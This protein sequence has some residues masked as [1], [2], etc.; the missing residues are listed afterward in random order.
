MLENLDLE[1]TNK[2]ICEKGMNCLKLLTCTNYC[3]NVFPGKTK[4]A[5][6][7][8][9]VAVDADSLLM[10]V[11]VSQLATVHLLVKINGKMLIISFVLPLS[12][13]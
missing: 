11:D 4:C 13:T 8:N 2:N 7:G 5:A 3:S 6:L 1:D 10:D 12:K 9:P